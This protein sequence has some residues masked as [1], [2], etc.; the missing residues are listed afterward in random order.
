MNPAYMVYRRRADN[1]IWQKKQKKVIRKKGI[2]KGEMER[3]N[4][5]AVTKETA[6]ELRKVNSVR[7]YHSKM[8]KEQ[9]VT[10]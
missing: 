10:R 2:D 7:T 3:Y 9:H 6:D 1:N 4:R 8:D 5:Q